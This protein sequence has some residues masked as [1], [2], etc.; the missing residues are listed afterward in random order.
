MKFREP[1][2][3][4]PTSPGAGT[5]VISYRMPTWLRDWLDDQPR[6]VQL[7]CGHK[8]DVKLPGVLMRKGF[9]VKEVQVWCD[10]G[11]CDG[12]S[13]VTAVLNLCQY[14]DIA[15]APIPDQPLF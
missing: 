11:D 15:A 12:F 10:L 14:K 5:S 6:Y 13:M 8:T 7:K 1:F 4:A 3:P 9:E 2:V